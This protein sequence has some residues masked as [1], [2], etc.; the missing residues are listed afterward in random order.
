MVASWGVV[1]Y[2]DYDGG[3]LVCLRDFQDLDVSVFYEIRSKGNGK[4]VA[5]SVICQCAGS[6]GVFIEGRYWEDGRPSV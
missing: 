1:V 4:V 2:V 6:G 5:G 3:G